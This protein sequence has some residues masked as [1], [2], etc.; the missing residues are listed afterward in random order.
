M[1]IARCTGA[2][3]RFGSRGAGSGRAVVFGGRD[4]VAVAD[5]EEGGRHDL[6]AGFVEAVLDVLVEAGV[7]LFPFF[8]AV[9]R[10][11]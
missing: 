5:A 4:C 10:R 3:S 7:E 2:I 1:R 9:E 11:R 8:G 6:D